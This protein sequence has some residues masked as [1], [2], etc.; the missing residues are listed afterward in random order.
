[1]ASK[2]IE[3]V[4]AEQKLAEVK[5]ELAALKDAIKKHEVSARQQDK[6]VDTDEH[7]VT[8]LFVQ[9]RVVEE[10]HDILVA[11]LRNNDKDGTSEQYHP[12]LDVS[13]GDHTVV[14]LKN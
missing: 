12:T 7:H 4:H 2:E 10:H 6:P 13:P 5:K 3:Q 8:E 1:M 9:K 14:D 11:R